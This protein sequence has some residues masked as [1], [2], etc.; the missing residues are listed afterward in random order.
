MT[1]SGFGDDPRAVAVTAS[2]ANWPDKIWTAGTVSGEYPVD[3]QTLVNRLR[4]TYEVARRDSSILDT[5]YVLTPTTGGFELRSIRGPGPLWLSQ[6]P[7]FQAKVTPTLTGT[8]L[9][10]K[11][12][13]PYQELIRDSVLVV[14]GLA[15]LLLPGGWAAFLVCIAAVAA[16]F[17][18]ARFLG[19]PNDLTALLASLRWSLAQAIHPSPPPA[20]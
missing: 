16:F 7:V 1:S 11:L 5:R 15:A 18:T 19:L 2:G 4:A 14:L 9:S 20:I 10:G 13:M 8:R 3:P 12:R 17:G 6:V